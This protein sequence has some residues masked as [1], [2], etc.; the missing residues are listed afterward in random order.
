MWYRLHMRATVAPRR[1]GDAALARPRLDCPCLPR[2][3]GACVLRAGWKSPPAVAAG[4]APREPASAR[5]VA[6]L[7]AGVSRPGA[8]PGPTVTVRM[9]EQR[10]CAGHRG[11]AR[12]RRAVAVR[13]RA[14]RRGRAP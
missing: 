10:T 3:R 9:K 11:P 14:A 4:L 13:G 12:S 7:P 6:V 2:K 5:P 8:M 1:A